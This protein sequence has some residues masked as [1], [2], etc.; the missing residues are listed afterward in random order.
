MG[1]TLITNSEKCIKCHSCE[2]ACS[3]AFFKEED[4]EKSRI[5]ITDGEI[6]VCN[7]CGECIK[8]CSEQALYRNNAGV[9]VLDSKKCVGCLI[10]VGFCSNLSMRVS[11]VKP[12]KCIA[13][14]I[15]VKACNQGALSLGGIS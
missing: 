10:C 9:V 11:E 3:K 1:K 13:C 6:N 5:K 15:C 8:V 12:F 4:I 7:Q 2:K 14:G